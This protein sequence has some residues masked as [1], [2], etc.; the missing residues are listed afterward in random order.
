[1]LFFIEECQLIAV[2][3]MLE[4]ENRHFTALVEVM[5]WGNDYQW[6]KPLDGR[7]GACSH[8]EFRLSAPQSTGGLLQEG[9]AD[10]VGLPMQ[11][12]GRHPALP[13]NCFC[14]KVDPEFYHAS[15]A[16]F[17]LQEIRERKKLSRWH[18]EETTDKSRVWGNWNKYNK[19]MALD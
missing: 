8:A 16:N 15:R 4:L 17:C 3:R 18:C 6:G 1:M 19:W 12:S 14:Q 7:G 10:T 5:D 13:R 11:C 9:P 2:E